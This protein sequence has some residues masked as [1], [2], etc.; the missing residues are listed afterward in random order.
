MEEQRAQGVKQKCVWCGW[1]RGA[2]TLSKN[3][4]KLRRCA[5]CRAVSYCG[6]ECQA[7]HWPHHREACHKAKGAQQGQEAKAA[8]SAKRHASKDASLP[9]SLAEHVRP[10]AVPSKLTTFEQHVIVPAFVP[11]GAKA[12]SP[13]FNVLIILHDAEGTAQEMAG[14]A[15]KMQLAHF[16]CVAVQASP[17]YLH[18]DPVQ[19]PRLARPT[20]TAATS[21]STSTTTTTSS[22]SNSNAHEPAPWFKTT[23]DSGSGNGAGKREP[24]LLSC[25]DRLVCLI[26]ELQESFG[27]SRKGI[28]LMG[29]GDGATAACHAALARVAASLRAARQDEREATTTEAIPPRSGNSRGGDAASRVLGGVVCVNGA[30]VHSTVKGGMAPFGGG[31]SGGGGGG[32]AVA[33]MPPVVATHA[34]QDPFLTSARVE[35]D[36]AKL[37]QAGAE[38]EVVHSPEPS[39]LSPTSMRAI[40]TFLG[41]HMRTTLQHL[42]DKGH[43][44]EVATN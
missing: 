18:P 3:A 42:A 28:F 22:N 36:A 27:Y 12:L 4:P 5:G 21:P 38:V 10:P 43:L 32:G 9:A 13:V 16:H 31:S 44:S 1:Q 6:R 14:L 25:T 15:R 39:I 41:K 33:Q 7:R 23:P 8:T 19:S 2:G 29:V 26:D 20:P 17:L 37:R 35:G 40:F 34:V 24:A 30:L 11:P